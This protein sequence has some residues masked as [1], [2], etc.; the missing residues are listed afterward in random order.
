MVQ[1]DIAQGTALGRA[2]VIG[3]PVAHVLILGGG[4][5]VSEY[6]V[7]SLC[8]LGL[9]EKA[10]VVDL[11]ENNLD[12]IQRR[13]PRI[14]VRRADYR[15]VLDDPA[16]AAR[17]GSAIVA[18]PNWLHED[19]CRRALHRG[20][21]VLCEKPLALQP[22][23]C[24]RLA[25]ESDRAGRMLS[26][27]MVRRWLPSVSALREAL[28][29]GLIGSLTSVTF[30]DGAPYAWLS[31]SGSFFR[32][33]SGGVL[34]D[35]GVHY[36]DLLQWLLGPLSP[37]SYT[38]DCRGGVEANAVYELKTASGIPVRLALSRTHTLPN[39]AVFRGARGELILEK[40]RVDRCRWVSHDGVL[41][42]DLTP[43][44]P[45]PDGAWE[46]TFE[47]CFHQQLAAFLAGA[48]VKGAAEV[49]AREAGSVVSLIDWAYRARQR[50]RTEGL[51]AESSRPKLAP[52]P[53]IVT[54]GTGFIGTRLV[55]RL[56]DL[57]FDSITVPVRSYRNCPGVACFPVNLPRVDLLDPAAV[58]TCVTGA[59]YV[60]HLA[61]G[62]DGTN[63]ARVT[64][65]GTRN[66]VEAAIEA[67]ADCVVVLSTMY[68]FG[69]K[70]QRNP[71]DESAPYAPRGGDYGKTK[72]AMERWCLR[73]AV[74]AGK[75]RIVVLNP[76]CVYGPGG[77]TY[78]LLP[79]ELAKANGFCWVEGGSGAANY[80]F[81][82]NLV[83]AI[84]LAAGCEAARGQRFIINDGA[85]TWREFLE[86]IVFLAT[87]DIPS[88]S[89]AELR[90]FDHKPFLPNVARLAK[91][92]L[93]QPGIRR[94]LRSS[95]LLGGLLAAGRSLAPALPIHVGSSSFPQAPRTSEEEPRPRPPGWL[96]DLFGPDDAVFAADKARR[97]L[98]WTSRVDLRE[99]QKVSVAWL[100][101]TGVL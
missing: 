38:D 63:C 71:A 24:A 46:H 39:R 4:S 58:R 49:N 69:G 52:A 18:L 34:A 56:N 17:F 67:G 95:R 53:V 55:E 99:G 76:S 86:P 42:G 61:Y 15:D 9:A 100:R 65:E 54:G 72:A 10:L 31:D 79:G 57:G 29:R 62:R 50:A 51:R 93:R 92:A 90:S 60:F 22:E 35:M 11:A 101:N 83:D 3:A 26:V 48:I 2:Q 1:T 7:P 25:E 30:D 74:T 6:H 5:V 97:V 88:H 94:E 66:V 91:F 77:R 32:P 20:L 44:K 8:A 23:A 82:D 13:F 78:T 80:V 73:R 41:Q 28:G 89:V 16:T 59:K 40:A 45:F 70:Q 27:G 85:T 36:L 37:V 19:A 68:V 21:H 64:I 14:A 81:V 12:S 33:E 87:A 75:T 98:N 96:A 47:S 84:V 43:A